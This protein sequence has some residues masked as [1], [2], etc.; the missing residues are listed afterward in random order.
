MKKSRFLD[1][2]ALASLVDIDQSKSVDLDKEYSSTVEQ[3]QRGITI[4]SISKT[5]GSLSSFMEKNM[6]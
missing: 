2:A 4:K 6:T 1:H 3:K 5:I